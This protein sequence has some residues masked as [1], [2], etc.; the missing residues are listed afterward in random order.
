MAKNSLKTLR[1]TK[2]VEEA[3]RL[4]ALDTLTKE[5]KSGVCF[6]IEELLNQARRYKGFNYT[7]WIKLGGFEKWQEAGQ[8]DWP[9]KAKFVY[10]PDGS[11]FD[12]FY[13]C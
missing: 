10:G 4:L 8:P 2:A 11:D 3:N 1:V 5:E 6:L 13:Y 12:R 7:Y 9:D